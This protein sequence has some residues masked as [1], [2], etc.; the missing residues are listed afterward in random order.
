MKLILGFALSH[1]KSTVQ[2]GASQSYFS[3]TLHLVLGKQDKAYCAPQSG[4]DLEFKG[5]V[6]YI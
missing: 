6:R 4:D 1:H 3:G 5:R 2:M